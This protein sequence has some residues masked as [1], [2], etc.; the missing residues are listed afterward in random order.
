MLCLSLFHTLTYARLTDPIEQFQ[1]TF[2][3]VKL[4][5]NF[6]DYFVN[7]REAY[8]V[9]VVAYIWFCISC[10]ICFHL[11]CNSKRQRNVL[12][13]Y[14][15]NFCF[16][17]YKKLR[18]IKR[19]WTNI[20]FAFGDK[21]QTLLRFSC[22]LNIFEEFV[23]FFHKITICKNKLIRIDNFNWIYLIFFKKQN[24]TI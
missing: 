20:Y 8:T 6:R 24:K 15:L 10:S 23:F 18:I 1:I 12:Q 7:V 3:F 9:C 19:V 5:R 13:F 11:F 4:L 2:F 22:W 21:E 14:E 17:L 16:L